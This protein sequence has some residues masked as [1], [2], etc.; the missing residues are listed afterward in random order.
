MLQIKLYKKEKLKE[1][2]LWN[3]RENSCNRQKNKDK[4][5]MKLP[6]GNKEPIK[7]NKKNKLNY[8][9]PIILEN[10]K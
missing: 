4:K 10:H 8:L 6:I 3:T 7:Q 9:E 1:L 2:K 5:K